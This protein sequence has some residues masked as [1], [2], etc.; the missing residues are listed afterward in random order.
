MSKKQYVVDGDLFE[1]AAT[2]TDAGQP[3]DAPV[4]TPTTDE[5]LRV[6][7]GFCDSDLRTY[8]ILLEA[9]AA[10]TVDLTER[11]DRDRSNINRSLSRLRDAG[12][13]TRRRRIL[14]SGGQTYQYVPRSP[15][16]VRHIVEAAIAE[17]A[18]TAHER[19]VSHID[20]LG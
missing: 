1:P 20:A 16:A 11:L 12:F 13:V 8:E 3:G 17:W 2:V 6:L 9:G 4:D 14:Q 10:T 7:F 15:E 5:A 19:L 18:E